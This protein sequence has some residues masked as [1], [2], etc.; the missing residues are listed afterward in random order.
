MSDTGVIADNLVLP[1]WFWAGGIVII[2][3]LIMIYSLN[4]AFRNT[5]ENL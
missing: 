3:I 5:K 4:Y 2:S 1:H